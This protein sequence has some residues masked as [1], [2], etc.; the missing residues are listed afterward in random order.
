MLFTKFLEK[1]EYHVKTSIGIA[2]KGYRSSKSKYLHGPGQG[3]QASGS[4]WTYISTLIIKIL[5]LKAK[6]VHFVDPEEIMNVW[7][8]IDGFVDDT[9]AWI[10]Q[11]LE[12]LKGEYDK[13]KLVEDIK[14]TA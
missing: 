9:T 13:D 7:R 1:A 6:G 3:G 11:F 8:V 2:E 14:A 10:N 5:E 4:S 12:A